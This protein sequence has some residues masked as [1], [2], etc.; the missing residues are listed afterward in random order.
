MELKIEKATRILKFSTATQKDL[1][2]Y[3][4]QLT[5][6]TY[7]TAEDK[8]ETTEVGTNETY[9]AIFK[10]QNKMIGLIKLSLNDTRAIGELT[11]SIPNEM[12]SLRYGTEAVH[13]ILKE[14]KRMN[15]KVLELSENTLTQRYKLQRPKLFFADTYKINFNFIQM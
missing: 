12:W 7:V 14:C 13:Q 3:K 1:K 11:V 15:I 4:R 10:D 6:C 8:I 5:Y 2:E 9:I